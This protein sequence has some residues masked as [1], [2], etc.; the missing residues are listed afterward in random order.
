[1]KV[2]HIISSGGMY[3]AEAVILNLSRT[4]E[5]G[6][7]SSVLGVFANSANPN[8]Q[9]HEA[10]AKQDIESHLILCN[11]QIDRGTI[12]AIRDLA[13]R[14]NADV[15]HAHGYKAD[16]YVYLALRSST[17]PW[18][19]P[20]IPGMTPTVCCFFMASWTDLCCAV[21]RESSPSRMKCGNGC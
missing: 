13:K 2:L 6:V 12:A 10:A 20:A 8:L 17:S 9:L 4:I 19:R 16:I 21:T 7:H 14:T 18:S 3:G 1:M 15:V 5:A 11:G